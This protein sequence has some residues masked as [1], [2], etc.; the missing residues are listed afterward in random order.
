VPVGTDRLLASLSWPGAAGPRARSA[1]F[2]PHGTF[3]AYS[4]PQGPSNVGQIDVHQAAPGTWTAIII[5]LDTLKY[6]RAR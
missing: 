4:I 3:S 6:P 5:Q 2:D 1:C